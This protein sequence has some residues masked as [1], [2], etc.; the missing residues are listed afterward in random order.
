MKKINFLLISPTSPLWRAG[1]DHRPAKTRV[2]RFSMLSS[3]YVAASMPSNVDTMIV[4]ED[5]EPV[6]F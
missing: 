2:F 3:L 6:D 4:D 5:V 1:T